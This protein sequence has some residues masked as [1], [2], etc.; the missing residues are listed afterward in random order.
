MVEIAG[1][2]ITGGA[3]NGIRLNSGTSNTIIH[4]NIIIANGTGIDARSGSDGVV[5]NNSII[6]NSVDGFQAIGSGTVVTTHNNIIVNNGRYGIWA[7]DYSSIT[8]VYND[9]W[10]NLSGDY[11]KDSLADLNQTNNLSI[12]P[13][14]LDNFYLSA[15][16]G[17]IDKGRP[18]AADNDPDGTRNDQGVYGGPYAVDFWP[19]PA[20]GPVVTDLSVTPPSVPVGGTLTIRATGKIR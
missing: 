20:G 14:F 9:V 2:T 7:N 15:G 1:F 19:Q 5:Y 18:I 11:F 10:S 12:D 4:N 8:A 17:C 6:Y 13:Q 3:T 16:S